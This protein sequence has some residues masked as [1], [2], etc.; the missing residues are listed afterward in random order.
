MVKVSFLLTVYYFR[1][2]TKL[3]YSSKI[4]FIK[5]NSMIQATSKGIFFAFSCKCKTTVISYGCPE[6]ILQLNNS[7]PKENTK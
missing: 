2:I 1:F 3:S 5:V 7:A 4:Y 6:S